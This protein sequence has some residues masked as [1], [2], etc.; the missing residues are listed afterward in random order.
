MMIV[1]ANG[2]KRAGLYQA[3]GGERVLPSSRDFF[4]K[5]DER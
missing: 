1:K 3:A 4:G 2:R 5:R